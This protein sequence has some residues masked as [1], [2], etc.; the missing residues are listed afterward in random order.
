MKTTIVAL[1][2]ILAATPFVTAWGQDKIDAPISAVPP[3]GAA[4]H[5][6]TNNGTRT[7]AESMNSSVSKEGYKH[8]TGNVANGPA[9]PRRTETAPETV[10]P[11]SASAAANTQQVRPAPAGRY[12][13]GSG[14]VGN[15]SEAGGVPG[16]EGAA[17]SATMGNTGR[18]N[19]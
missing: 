9:S 16:T 14:E 15:S 4:H 7:P 12:S 18:V 10:S 17:A 13:A 3:A 19:R 5:P 6:S 8:N 1:A 11:P 2:S